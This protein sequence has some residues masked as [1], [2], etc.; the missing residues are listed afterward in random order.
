MEDNSLEQKFSKFIIIV[1]IVIPVVVAIL[2]GVKLKDFGYNVE[3]LSFLPPIY[4]TINGMTALVLIAAV[5]A[6][7]NGK[8]ILHE[9]LMASAIAL[10]VAFLVMYVAYHMTADSTKFGGEG[11][12][13]YVYF[14]ILITH[15]I[16]SIAIIPMVLITYVRALSQ[17]FDTH[18]KIAKITF[19]IWL[20]VAVTGVVVYLMISPYYV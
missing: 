6:I 4:A 13:R 9:R 12:I 14:F 3:P 2:F 15:I 7:K 1:S 20:Y 11:T 17:K 8:R 16:L 19:P 18:K 5:L 10:S